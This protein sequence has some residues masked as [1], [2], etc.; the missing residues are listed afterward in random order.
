MMCSSR[1]NIKTVSFGI[2]A[3]VAC[4]TVVSPMQFGK[5]IKFSFYHSTLNH[6]VTAITVMKLF[7][8]SYN[9]YLQCGIV[10]VI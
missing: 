8:Q 7:F 5:F 3:L 4:L 2:V 6:F 9:F 10:I 1:V